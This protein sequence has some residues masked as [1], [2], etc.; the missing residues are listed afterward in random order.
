MWN[1]LTIWIALQQMMQD[2][3]VKFKSRI[4]M[5]KAAFNK[6]K[7]LFTSK[8]DLHF[9]KK[10]V[11]CYIWGI[12][13]IMLKLEHLD[14]KY[15]ESFEMWCWRRIEKISFADC[16]R[17]EVLQRVKEERKILQTIKRR[18]A[19]WIG[20]IMRRNCLLKH[21]IEVRI[22]GRREVMGR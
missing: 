1:I 7:T 14:Q 5:A 9:R 10:L 4:A 20:Y 11:K 6:K 21:V 12:A 18:K 19:N 2:V 13:C 15:P 17:H 16:V 3:L 22:G 8:E